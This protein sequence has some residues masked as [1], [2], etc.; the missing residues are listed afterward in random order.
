MKR[1]TLTIVGSIAITHLS[2]AANPTPSPAEQ[3]AVFV[4][5]ANEIPQYVKYFR[6]VGHR[7]DSDTAAYIFTCQS[8]D[9]GN[10]EWFV[11]LPIEL[12]NNVGAVCALFNQATADHSFW[13]EE[14]ADK[15]SAH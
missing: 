4:E 14:L 5:V 1:L 11:F 6:L 15:S 13:A 9:P 7:Y 10:A 3:Y 12:A 8:I 2:L